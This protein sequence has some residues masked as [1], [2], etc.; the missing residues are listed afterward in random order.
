MIQCFGF[1]FFLADPCVFLKLFQ[2]IR[3]RTDNE[4]TH[5]DWMQLDLQVT[6]TDSKETLT[7]E[8]LSFVLQIK[9]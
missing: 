8:R 2:F 3:T 5:T 7:R 4:A 9:E 6:H 1:F